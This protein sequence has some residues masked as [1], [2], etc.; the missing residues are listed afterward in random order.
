MTSLTPSE[1]HVV[2][3]LN[4]F[5]SSFPQCLVVRDSQELIRQL[6]RFTYFYPSKRVK[7]PKDWYWDYEKPDRSLQTT[8]RQVQEWFTRPDAL[9]PPAAPSHPPSPTPMLQL[10][11]PLY[12]VL[13][14]EIRE[15]IF[16]LVVSSNPEGEHHDPNTIPAVAAVS[17]LVRQETLQLFFKHN[18]FAFPT[19][20]GQKT[21]EAPVKCLHAMRPHLPKIHQMTFFVAYYAKNDDSIDADISVTIRH[22][23]SRGCWTTTCDDD[24]SPS[25]M[26]MAPEDRCALKRDGALL[27]DFMG[28]MV[29]GRSR[30]DLTPEYLMWLMHDA[31][32]FYTVEKMEGDCNGMEIQNKVSRVKPRVRRPP[33]MY[34]MD[35]EY[36]QMVWWSG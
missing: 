26:E 34:S 35:I 6:Y 5:A 4:R 25:S 16:E 21:I 7:I 3:K 2:H 33:D 15:Y 29:D 24:W 30:A 36:D 14:T 1:I 31:R 17:R 8:A 22:N 12:S 23:P 19:D 11:S 20:F 28:H 10:Q 13:P 32:I 9:K 27:C 18:H